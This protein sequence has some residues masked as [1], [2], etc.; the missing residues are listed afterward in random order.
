MNALPLPGIVLKT[1]LCAAALSCVA[2]VPSAEAQEQVDVRFEPGATSATINGT[3][4]GDE[5]IDYVLGARAAYFFW[6]SIVLGL[7]NQL[8]L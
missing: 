5:Y 8:F 2:S 6:I 4:V 3:I 1:L 7:C